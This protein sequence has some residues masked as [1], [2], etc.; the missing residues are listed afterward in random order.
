MQILYEKLYENTSRK[1]LLNNEVTVNIRG[2]D[3]TTYSGLLVVVSRSAVCIGS[4]G[5]NFGGCLL[6]RLLVVLFASL[7]RLIFTIGVFLGAG[8]TAGVGD[9]IN[10]GSMVGMNTIIVVVIVIEF[11]LLFRF[12]RFIT[13]YFFFVLRLF[14]FLLGL[15]VVRRLMLG[16]L[17][18]GIEFGVHG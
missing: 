17:V 7:G 12:T 14:L 8:F 4:G 2:L 6:H 15:L 5:D 9:R 1:G 10:V 3:P 18:I 11:T 16:E 13:I